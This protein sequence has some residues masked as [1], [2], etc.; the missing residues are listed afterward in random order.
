MLFPTDQFWAVPKTVTTGCERMRSRRREY[1]RALPEFGYCEQHNTS[2]V[3]CCTTVCTEFLEARKCKP[4]IC[5]DSS[6]ILNPYP[7]HLFRNL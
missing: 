7:N 4:E 2:L 1:F 6:L 5:V 3:L